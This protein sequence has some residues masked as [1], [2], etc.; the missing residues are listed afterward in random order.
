MSEAVSAS[1]Y[2]IRTARAADI[3][4]LVNMINTAFSVE[5]FLEGT[6]TSA[7]ELAQ[8]IQQEKLLL[9]EKPP[10]IPLAS[11]CCEERGDHGYMGMLAVDPAVQGRGL[12]RRLVA[13]AE[14][15]FRS[16]GMKGVEI[17]VLSLRTEL[18]AIYRRW[19]FVEAG[20]EPFHHPR[21]FRNP[22]FRAACHCIVM[23]KAL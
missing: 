8:E 20:T 4:A 2:R 11:V 18:P 12:A 6:R 14:E 13:A 10:G 22:S 5:E 1:A 19:G 15:R 7:E 3:P 21:T 17:I 9:L 16:K 23:H